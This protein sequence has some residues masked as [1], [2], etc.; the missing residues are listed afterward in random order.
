MEKIYIYGT[1]SKAIKFL[2][3][4]ALK[5]EVVGFLDSDISRLGEHFLGTKISHISSINDN[6]YD[7]IVLASS[8]SAQILDYAKKHGVNK[9]I[10]EVEDISDVVDTLAEY[11]EIEKSYRRLN[12]VNSN[13][14]A[15][16]N[17][18]LDGAV[19][20]ASRDVLLELIAKDGIAAELGVA[21]GDYTSKIIKIAKPKKLH[22]VDAWHSERYNENLFN[23]VKDRFKSDISSGKIEVHRNLSTLAVTNFPD[24]YFD[25]IY[26]DTSHSY[27]G[28]KAEL[29]LYASKVKNDG[30]IAGHDY[31]MGNWESQLRYGVMEAVHEFCVEHGWR[32]KY[33][34]MDLS[35]NQS[36]AIVKLNN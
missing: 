27:E 9:R 3:I 25:W 8:Y 36:F 5:Y 4:I 11:A 32:I 29:E 19:L 34:T 13:K 1:G 2:P 6:D 7:L 21:S 33:L 23:D 15:L 28:T 35:E 20:I 17:K 31:T 12:S 16:E 30:I 24:D 10:V 14:F 18:H 26:I 22:L